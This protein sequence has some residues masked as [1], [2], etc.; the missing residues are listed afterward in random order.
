MVK[1][2][3]ALAKYLTWWFIKPLVSHCCVANLTRML[4]TSS[5]N[6]MHVL[7][8]SNSISLSCLEGRKYIITLFKCIASS[9]YFIKSIASSRRVED[10]LGN[11]L[12]HMLVHDKYS[13]ARR[14]SRKLSQSQLNNSADCFKSS[15]LL[16]LVLQRDS[17]FV[18]RNCHATDIALTE[19]AAWLEWLLNHPQ[20]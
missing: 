6:Q 16:C 11:T 13:P 7:V 2:L 5:F 1:A 8:A 19:L 10:T 20:W 3:F 9:H 15:C 18:S 4:Q 17:R 14:V 12:V